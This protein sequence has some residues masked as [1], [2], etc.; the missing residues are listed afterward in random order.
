VDLPEKY[1]AI[2]IT[3][4]AMPGT[5]K[6]LPP[7]VSLIKT[8]GCSSVPFLL[9]IIRRIYDL[10]IEPAD[11]WIDRMVTHLFLDALFDFVHFLV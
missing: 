4:G 2:G 5:S 7:Y 11:F 6:C 3:R 10:A 1:L 9:R 8:P